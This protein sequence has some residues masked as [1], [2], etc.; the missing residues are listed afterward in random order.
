MLVSHECP[1]KLLE[2]S[3]KF[4]DY[5]YALVHLFETEP[6]YKQFYIDS[7]KQGRIVYLDNS[8]FELKK[9][10]DADKFAY[11]CE[12]LGSIN[13]DNFYYIIPDCLHDA[14]KTLKSFFNFINNYHIP[15]KIIGV[16]QGK[17]FED[18][19]RCINNMMQYAD[20][21]AFPFISLN[22]DVNDACQERIDRIFK[23]KKMGYLDKIKLHLLGCNLPQEYKAYKNLNIFSCDTSNPIVNGIFNV[24]YTENGLTYKNQTKLVDL[25][26]TDIDDKQKD[27]IMYN[28]YMFK[29]FIG[30]E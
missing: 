20:I 9:A 30:R 25:L 15:G 24:R 12:Q 1:L 26:N 11:Y 6:N 10:F 29:K 28:I 19:L 8:L 7:L 18:Q 14:D 23:L 21:I 4:N 27:D 22:S 3:R 5:D 17:T 16:A 2:A 13:S